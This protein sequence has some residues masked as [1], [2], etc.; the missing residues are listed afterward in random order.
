M[1]R[2]LWFLRKHTIANGAIAAATDAGTALTVIKLQNNTD[3]FG[4]AGENPHIC[5]PV[6]MRDPDCI[7]FQ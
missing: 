6:F 3:V 7:F 5:S 1:S 2:D 4:I